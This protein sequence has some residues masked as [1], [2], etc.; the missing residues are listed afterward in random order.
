MAVFS[1]SKGIFHQYYTVALAPGVAALAGAG[2]VSLWNLGR[3]TAWLRWA[4]PASVVSTGVWA[5]VLLHR[6]P[7]YDSWLIPAITAGAALGGAGLWV[8][9]HLRSRALL[10]VAAGV[11]TVAL[12]A[13]PA[14]YAV[15]TIRS[16]AGGPLASAGP[17]TGGTFGP[18]GGP[19]GGGPPGGARAGGPGQAEAAD[20]GLVTYLE[21]NRGTAKYL[22]AAFGSQS[23]ASIIIASGRPVITIGGFSGGDPAPT[24]AQFT[25]LVASGQVRYVLVGAGGL[26]GRGPGGASGAITDWVV[27]NGTQVPAAAYGGGGGGAGTLYQ[28]SGAS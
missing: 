27:S 11:A 26:G 17:S 25:S 19:P 12:L 9:F 8:A 14:A 28:L 16:P 18:G 24:L 20:A 3:T 23:S 21:A 7:A 22:V 10:A 2:A 1:L 15:T 5:V 6:T 4:L 13:G